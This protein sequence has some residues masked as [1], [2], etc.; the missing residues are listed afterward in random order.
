MTILTATAA[1]RADFDELLENLNPFTIVID[2]TTSTGFKPLWR[3][4][5]ISSLVEAI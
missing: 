3:T 2:N 4:G 5:S 1:L